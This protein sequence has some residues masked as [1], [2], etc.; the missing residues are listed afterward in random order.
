[1][2]KFVHVINIITKI[3]FD[4]NIY[5][6]VLGNIQHFFKYKKYLTQIIKKISNVDYKDDGFNNASFKTFNLLP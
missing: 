3:S 5:S 6:I 1:M 4:F 2:S